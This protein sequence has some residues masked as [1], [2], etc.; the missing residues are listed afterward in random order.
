MNS[1]L[2][3]IRFVF[4]TNEKNISILELALEYF[5]KYNNFHDVKI[6]VISNGYLTQDLPFKE[7]VSYLDGKVPLGS[8]GSHFSQVMRNCL[9]LI[10][11]EYI[12]FFCDD[13]FLIDYT[14]RDDLLKLLSIIKK[15]N[16][17]YFC[18]DELAGSENPE[19]DYKKIDS[20]YFNGSIFYR[21]N[22]YRYLFSVQPSIWKVKS[23]LE[24]LEK[25]PKLSLH[26]FDETIKELKQNNIYNCACT[27]LDSHFSY[28]DITN[29]YFIIAYCELVRHGVFHIP[30]NGFPINENCNS[31]KLIRH[32][33]ESKKLLGDDKYKKLFI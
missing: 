7:R 24:I 5:L 28:K 15:Q 29:D 19:V 31:V 6:S 4:N 21:N 17:D 12:F 27:N 33:C 11:E 13:Y 23:Y 8:D 32:L 2:K 16:I 20:E 14:K 9:K 25:Y 30:E 22:D 1:T 18:F 10:E 26:Q 3:N